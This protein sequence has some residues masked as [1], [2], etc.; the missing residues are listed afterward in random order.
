MSVCLRRKIMRM[1]KLSLVLLLVMVSVMLFGLVACN[2]SSGDNSTTPVIPTPNPGGDIVDNKTM[3]DSQIAWQLFKTVA[4]NAGAESSRGSRY[5]SVDTTF[6]LGFQKDSYDSLVTMRFA[7]KIDTEANSQAD[8]TSEILVEFRQFKNDE[9]GDATVDADRITTL[10]SSGQGKLLFGAYYYEGKLVT[11]MRGLKKGVQVVWTKDIDMGAFVEKFNGLLEDLNLTQVVFDKLLGLDV[12]ALIKKLAGLDLVNVTVEQLLVNVLLGGARS[13]YIDYGSG[14]AVLQIPI[15]LGII[16]GALP[17]VQGL[18]PENITALVKQILGLDLGKLGSLAGMALYLEADIR[19]AN[20]DK[21]KLTCIKFDIDTNFN[22]YGVKEVEERYGKFQSEVGISLGYAKA[23]FAGSP[24]IDVKGLLQKRTKDNVPFEDGADTS[25]NFYSHVE[26]KIAENKQTY[27][28]LTLDAE[29]KL[30]LDLKEGKLTIQNAID[31]F[32]TLISNIITKIVSPEMMA[33]LS[34]LFAKDIVINNQKIELSVA[35]QGK[36]NT[37]N[38]KETKILAEV[39]GLDSKKRL[40]AYYDGSLEGVYIDASGVLGENGTKFRVDDINV[41]ELLDSLIDKLFDTIKNAIQGDA[42]G[43]ASYAQLLDDADIIIEHDTLASASVDTMSLISAIVEKVKVDMDGNIFNIKGISVALTQDVLDMIFGLVFTGDNAGAKIPLQSAELKYEN[44][45][46]QREKRLGLTA[47]LLIPNTDSNINNG[48]DLTLGLGGA[49]TFGN[50]N[51]IDYFND[52]FAYVQEHANEYLPILSNGELNANLL[53]VNVSTG[54]KIDFETLK[55]TLADLK[56]D[57]RDQ[58]LGDSFRGILIDLLIELGNIKGGLK[59][60]LSADI[61]ATDGIDLNAILKS[62]AKIVIS[63]SNGDQVLSLY[64]QDGVLYLDASLLSSIK[65]DKVKVDLAELLPALGVGASTSSKDAYVVDDDT[66]GDGLDTTKLIGFIA[67]VFQGVKIGNNAI[68]VVIGGGILNELLTMLG[69]NNPATHWY[70][71]ANG[72][73]VEI[74]TT[75]APDDYTGKY[76]YFDA[77]ANQYKVA[78]GIDINFENSDIQGGIR[79]AL[80]DGLNLSKLELGVFLGLGSSLNADISIMGITAG[81]SDQCTKYLD[82]NDANEYLEILKY[83]YISLDLSLG[84]DFHADEGTTLMQFGI[85]GTHYFDEETRQFVE[86][87]KATPVPSGYLGKL[88]YYDETAGQYVPETINTTEFTFDRDMNL[89]YEFRL[90]GQIDLSPILAYLF[91]SPEISTK[92]NS[93]SLLIELTGKKF[94]YDRKVLLGLYYTGSQLY[95]DASN[96]GIGKVKADVDLYEIILG[97]LAK[98]SVVSINGNGQA[99]DAITAA[100]GDATDTKAKRQLALSIIALLSSDSLKIE[101]AKG[102]TELVYEILGVDANDVTAW[103]DI[104][105][106]NL[107]AHDGKFFRVSGSVSNV[108]GQETG[109]AEIYGRTVSINLGNKQ[110]PTHWY[111]NATGEYIAVADQPAPADYKGKYYYN[112]FGTYKEYSTEIL[113][114]HN[115]ESVS[116]GKYLQDNAFEDASLFNENGDVTIPSIYAEIKGTISIGADAGNDKWTIGE[117]ISN[118]LGD[119]NPSLKSFISDLLLQFNTPVAAGSDIGF[120][121]ALNARLNPE[122]PIDLTQNVYYVKHVLTTPIALTSDFDYVE[123]YKIDEAGK[124][125]VLLTE[126]ERNTYTGQVFV[127]YYKTDGIALAETK[128]D[129]AFRG[130]AFII[131]GDAAVKIN[132]TDD[133]AEKYKD[134]ALYSAASFLDIAYILSHSDLAIEIYNA[135]I[136]DIDGMSNAQKLE[137]VILALRVVYAGEENGKS[138]STLYLDLKDDFHLALT[139]IPLG[140]LLGGLITSSDSTA[141]TSDDTPDTNTKPDIMGII[142]SSLGNLISRIGIGEDNIKVNFA[143]ALVATLVSMISGKQI[144]ADNFLKL[145][146]DNSYLAFMWNNDSPWKSNYKLDL[147]VKADPVSLGI[148]L[149]G[150]DVEIGKDNGVLPEDFDASVYTSFENLNTLSLNVELGLELGLKKQDEEIRLEKY[151]DL[152]IKDLGLKLGI[153]FKDDVSYKIGLTVG[154]NLVLNEANASRMIVELKNENSGESILSVYVDGGDIYFDFGELGGNKPFYLK[155]TNFSEVICNYVK[156]L[157][158]DLN[159]VVGKGGNDA[160]TAADTA[161]MSADEKMQLILGISE[162]KL[163]VLVMENVIVGLIAAITSGTSGDI[164]IA[165]VLEEFDLDLS[166]A[167]DFQ[168]DPSLRLDLNVD[169]NLI[170]VG[171]GVKDIALATGDDTQ[172]RKTIDAKVDTIVNSGRFEE[173]TDAHVIAVDLSLIVDYYGSATYTY[174]DDE[175]AL[176][177]INPAERYSLNAHDNRFVQDND[178]RYIR[179]GFTFDKLLDVI[180][181]MQGLESITKTMLPQIRI[182]TANKE[183][184]FTTVKDAFSVGDLLQRLGLT[185]ALTDK[186]DDGFKLDINARLNLEDM[187]LNDLSQ[188]DFKN[189]NLSLETIL[190]GLEA[191][192]GIDFTYELGAASTAKLDIY[193]IDGRIYVD[194]SGIGGPRVQV[195]LLELLDSLGVELASSSSDAIIADGETPDD[196]ST[197][198]NKPS[199][200][201][202]GIVN[203]LIKNV[204]ITAKPWVAGSLENGNRIDN[205]GIFFRSNAINDLLSLLLKTTIESDQVVLD[206]NNSGLYLYPQTDMY[207]EDMLALRLRASLANK[208]DPIW[209]ANGEDYQQYTM[210]LVLALNAQIGLESTS[211]NEEGMLDIDERRQFISLNEYVENILGL[212]NGF[213]DEIYSVEKTPLEKGIYYVFN[214]DANGNYI[215]KSGMYRPINEGEKIAE[216]TKR[217]SRGYA[218]IV[219]RYVENAEGEYILDATDGTYRLISNGED[220]SGKQRYAFVEEV[221][222]LTYQEDV[223]GEY[224]YNEEKGV[225]VNKN[226]ADAPAGATKYYTRTMTAIKV[227]DENGNESVATVKDVKVYKRAEKAVYQDQ[228]IGLSVSGLIYFNSSSAETTN[229]GGLISNLFGDMIINLQT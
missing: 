141:T 157:L 166:V 220:V 155:N 151:L 6:I 105:W 176:S 100:E 28:L 163:S 167:V 22:S 112:W 52:A 191:H 146:S 216:G 129:V 147:K 170:N 114:D 149:S 44:D 160:S 125:Y 51:N 3:L 116:M 49:I 95:I 2:T 158:G 178:G 161:E 209:I 117:W 180:L 214:E 67:G 140:D 181:G 135:S 75:P 212:V 46:G 20:T 193:L 179:E 133:N 21:A 15:D 115:G 162:G 119:D 31:S 217:Y 168:L 188:L 185:L 223:N 137:K 68:E 34:K 82:E 56:I 205:V 132:V 1:R 91:G 159:S 89:N 63:K 156:K 144:S 61:D 190:A 171:I 113:I 145:D 164:D 96:F 99:V 219:G 54:I 72:V 118:F 60:D 69:I 73:Y 29:I 153:D 110:G 9:L 70:D 74:A 90:A 71:E 81:L 184:G 194:A 84:L 87:T 213:R 79:I 76:Y 143:Q 64:L 5:I 93:T 32:G 53:H 123:V 8:D 14:H 7:G 42:T 128:H 198:D 201:V 40:G 228:N 41:N 215:L 186:V 218:T 80:N 103:L 172:T 16:V 131:K 13:R 175:R 97:L 195:D 65:V 88:Y 189:L 173:L 165:K 58:E 126:D 187:G 127:K 43:S 39:R 138:V 174:V 37:K 10:S 200:D 121:I 23:D 36:I 225:Y 98:D 227:T 108:S 130:E 221:Y 169:S 222:A 102:L 104:A 47:K 17:L 124:K 85:K 139:N 94:D 199:V 45:G 197:K 66:K 83:P 204:I 86:I 207:G 196:D 4:L 142:S 183:L 120:R 62:T 101:L 30:T 27:S 208:K 134:V 177:R 48:L 182:S 203:K 50:I 25:D 59:L 35:L 111:N 26:T 136:E 18:I 92:D 11:D 122:V 19:E 55:G 78:N 202:V 206:E 106:D 211:G 192:I 154:A 109:G 77:S 24:D 229:A 150:I 57:L 33:S 38:P 148:T 224:V 226:S 107:E 12:G 210:D 152:L